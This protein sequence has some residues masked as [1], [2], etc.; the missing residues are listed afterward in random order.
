MAF[1]F[2]IRTFGCQMNEHD[3]ERM[4][5]RLLAAGW[6]EVS[7]PRRADLILVNS[8]SVRAKPEH[9]A[10]SEIGRFQGARRSRGVRLVLAGCVAQQEG[11]ALLS[12]APFLDAVIGPDAVERIA[13]VAAA[14]ME[15]RGPLLDLAPHS[16]LAPG[17]VPLCRPER[18]GLSALVTIMKGCNNFCS[19]CVVPYVRGREISRPIADILA[20][21]ESL[22][23]AGTREVTL[24]G[25]NVNSFRDRERGFADL[26]SAI[27][28]QGA[29]E[30]IRFT[31]SHPKDL[32]SELIAAMA[33]LPRVCEHLHLPLQAGSDDVLQRMNRGYDART[34]LERVDAVRS[35]V[36]GVS[37]TTDLIVGFPG[38]RERDFERT[39]EVV[40]RAAFDQAYSFCYSP[41]P[42]T[43]ASEWPD[44]VPAKEKKSRLDR[45]QH[46]LSRLESASLQR[47][48]GR[49]FEVLYEGPS[50]RDPACG[51]GRTRCNRVV[52]FPL[53]GGLRTGDLVDV[54]I[55]EA[56][57]HT[58]WG[59]VKRRGEPSAGQGSG[60]VP[61]KK[62]KAAVDTDLPA[63]D[64]E[65]G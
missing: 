61:A 42:Q 47:M 40:E 8:C 62:G 52:N 31:T 29:V 24:L 26:L 58:L 27:D 44:D 5:Q 33:E 30:R 53:C 43:R 63:R 57:G 25:Q 37:V 2:Y 32:S 9:K 36:A 51:T 46:L 6:E 54:L 39:L 17:F 65:M 60:D 13:S 28:A 55:D 1:R 50:R 21:V 16:H 56:R 3:S 23:R 11:E 18:G 64:K 12:R 14:L 49:A 41:R 15:G 34:Y 45:L 48:V 59:T 10:I 4:A 22:A 38:E 35:R 20:E 19:F 7:E